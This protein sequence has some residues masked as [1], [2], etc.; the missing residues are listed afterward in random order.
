[1]AKAEYFRLACDS[2]AKASFKFF[3][4]SLIISSLSQWSA[5]LEAIIL[6]IYLNVEDV[7]ARR[8]GNAI[9]DTSA[10]K[11]FNRVCY[12]SI[13]PCLDSHFK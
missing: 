1:L 5:K 6:V 4:L 2:P 8:A 11:E 7:L 9:C 3:S 13:E 10:T 12:F